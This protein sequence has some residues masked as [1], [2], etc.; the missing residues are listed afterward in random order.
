MNKLKDDQYVMFLFRM[1]YDNDLILTLGP[2]QKINKHDFKQLLNSYITL[3]HIKDEMYRNTPMK[4][5]I[6]SYK[7]I[8]EDKLEM[9]KS[10]I[11]DPA[12][13]IKKSSILYLLWL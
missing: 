11:Y 10:R 4:N 6:L 8:P 5:I 1:A 12:L 9:K 13:K 7:I 3:L 2:Q